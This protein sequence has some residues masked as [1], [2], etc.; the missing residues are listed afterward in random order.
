[1]ALSLHHARDR[2]DWL[3]IK[4]AQ[5]NLWQKIAA[6]T[7][8]VVTPGNIITLAGA[9]FTLTGLY[10][11]V[12]PGGN[13]VLGLCL[14]VVGRLADVADGIIAEVTG[15]KS[16]AGEMLDAV[17]DKILL[18]MVAIGLVFMN[19]LPLLVAFILF[20]HSLCNS[21]LAAIARMRKISLHPNRAG[22]LAVF[23]SWIVIIMF[24][25]SSVAN[26]AHQFFYNASLI[27]GMLFFVIFCYFGVISSFFYYKNLREGLKQRDDDS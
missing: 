5:R 8:G 19:L 16:P 17:T 2:A 22:K 25:L 3:L 14:I 10:E 1:M 6:G 11:L 15:T 7:N 21:I 20:L 12:F 4:P 23:F 27:I 13:D 18:F 9:F 24:S 26:D